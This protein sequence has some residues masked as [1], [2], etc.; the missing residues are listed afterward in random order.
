V[1]P[2]RRLALSSSLLL[3]TSC[4]AW[5][6]ATSLEDIRDDTVRVRTAEWSVTMEHATAYGHTIQGT[7]VTRGGVFEVSEACAPPECHRVDVADAKVAVWRVDGAATAGLVVLSVVAAVLTFFA[8][9]A[10]VAA[11]AMGGMK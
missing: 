4:H 9:A 6:P 1:T 11:A 5:M 8:G 7:P 10:M 2:E 3:V